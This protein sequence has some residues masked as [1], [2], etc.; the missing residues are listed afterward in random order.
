MN[1]IPRTR[2]RGPRR[3]KVDPDHLL[4]AAQAVFAA[5][6]LKA[7]TMRAIARKAGCDPALLY[8]HFDGKEALFRAL[9]ERR[10]PALVAEVQ[11]L[12]DPSD[13]RP[14]PLRLW[15]LLHIQRRHLGNDPGLRAMVR[16]ELARGAEGLAVL[17]E[18]RIRPL[19]SAIRQILEQGVERGEVRPSIHP[20]MATF[21]LS[22][23]QLEILDVL[24]EVLP[25]LMPLPREEAVPAGMRAWLE[26]FWRG[27]ALDPVQPL[28]PL[29]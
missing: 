3:T 15:D 4:E 24:P 18:D 13:P 10:F 19:S 9:L 16:G 20:L 23:M 11:Q 17:L 6:G 22:K 14:T 29:P 8:Y 1:P 2:A 5:E 28:P 7:A 25:R 27:I 12:A 21:F 26:L